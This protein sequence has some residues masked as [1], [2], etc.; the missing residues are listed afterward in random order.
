MLHHQVL[1]NINTTCGYKQATY[2]KKLGHEVRL[3]APGLFAA[4]LQLLLQLL[5]HTAS[6]S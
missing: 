6:G 2:R 5:N 3:Q 1:S 4:G